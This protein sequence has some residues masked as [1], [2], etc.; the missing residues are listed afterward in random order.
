MGKVKTEIE[1]RLTQSFFRGL[2][3]EHEHTVLCVMEVGLYHGPEFGRKM[4]I[5]ILLMPPLDSILDTSEG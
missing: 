4:G 2:R 1:A 3:D 5:R